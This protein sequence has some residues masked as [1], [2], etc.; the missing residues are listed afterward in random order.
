[1]Q[2]SINKTRTNFFVK[3][4]LNGKLFLWSDTS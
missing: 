2:H 3:A 4:S 1:L